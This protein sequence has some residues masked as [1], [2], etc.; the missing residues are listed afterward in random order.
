MK[1]I[2]GLDSFKIL[3]SLVKNSGGFGFLKL[4]A[5]IHARTV[6]EAVKARGKHSSLPVC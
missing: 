2:D 3:G 5:V 6:N 4:L 1:A